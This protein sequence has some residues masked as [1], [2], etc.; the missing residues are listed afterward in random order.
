M[1]LSKPYTDT[2]TVEW[3]TFVVTGAPDPQAL[4]P[5]DYTARERHRDVRAPGETTHTVPVSVNGDVAVEPDEYFVVSFHD[6][7]NA[8]IGGFYGLGFGVIQNDD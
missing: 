5:D 2:V 7:T 1:S 4:P 8:T 3:T 6:P